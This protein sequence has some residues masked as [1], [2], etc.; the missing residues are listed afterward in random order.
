M[1]CTH[2]SLHHC[3]VYIRCI[4]TSSLGSVLLRSSSLHQHDVNDGQDDA[5]RQ[6]DPDGVGHADGE[7]N[8]ADQVGDEGDAGHRDGVGQ[9]GGHMVHMVTVRQQKT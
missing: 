7:Q 1:R 5:Q 9:L 2:S 8:A 6:S 4:P 3:G